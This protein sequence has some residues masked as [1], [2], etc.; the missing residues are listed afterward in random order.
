MTVSTTSNKIKYDGNGATTLFSFPFKIFKNEELKVIL[1]TKADKIE[2]VLVLDV[3]YTV[4]ISKISNGGEI[5]TTVAHSSD[6]EILIKRVLDQTQE[7]SF[8]ISSNIPEVSIENSLDK[9][10][11]LTQDLKEEIS[12]TIK[13]KEGS[14]HENITIPDPEAGKA[15]LWN[16]AE[17]NLENSTDNFNEI[18]SDSQAA[19]AAAEAAQAISEAARDQAQGYAADASASAAASSWNDVIQ[20]Q[21]SDSPYSVLSTHGGVLFEIDCSGGN[22]VI[23]LP[24]VASL[25]LTKS[26]SC[27]F[28][29]IDNST[30]NITINTNG[31]DELDGNSDKII[32]RQYSGV[33]LIPDAEPI[34][35]T[36]TS[37]TFGETTIRGAGNPSIYKIFDAE[38]NSVVGFTNI[39]INNIDPISVDNDYKV[40]SFPASFPTIILEK[41][42]KDKINSTRFHYSLASG[43]FKVLV[44]DQSSNLL[45]ELEISKSGTAIPIIID[46]PLYNSETTIQLS[47]EDISS[48][49]GLFIDDVVFDDDPH[50]YKNLINTQTSHYTGTGTKGTNNAFRFSTLG[51]K[52]GSHIY[53]YSDSSSL[54]TRFTALR[55][56]TISLSAFVGGPSTSRGFYIR[57]N[58]IDLIRETSNQSPLTDSG[59]GSVIL[60]LDPSDYLDVYSSESGFNNGKVTVS[61]IATNEYMTSAAK[62]LKNYNTDNGDFTISGTGWTTNYASLTPYK[63]SDGKWRISGNMDI[64]LTSGTFGSISISG[65]T[66]KSGYNQS[67]TGLDA[68]GVVRSLRVNGGAGSFDR[69]G[70]FAV[71][72]NW[73]NFDLELEGKPDWAEDVTSNFLAAI[74]KNYSQTVI[75]STDDTE[76]ELNLSNLSIGKMYKLVVNLSG[77]VT[78]G[79]L[80]LLASHNGSTILS[81]IVSNSSITLEEKSTMKAIEFEATAE[82]VVFTKTTT[83]TTKLLSTDTHLTITELNNTESIGSFA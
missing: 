14:D 52:S 58:G 60:D 55:K 62:T 7:T 74:P 56:C 24:S 80:K 73:F 29:K 5:N 79:S 27:G 26:W 25:D 72:D 68:T 41:R 43:T 36:W 69:L 18:V 23:N 46:Y 12:R 54:G 19:Q 57:K 53:E 76:S 48:A 70:T 66:F 22:V 38:D 77:E 15:L 71:S 51:F 49:T 64:S 20:L 42:N 40:D 6:Y 75:L 59:S 82:T 44:K 17:N 34:P 32:T 16:D 50:I 45:R 1:I 9:S 10:V 30:N 47:I 13:L 61:A 31:T 33:T 65:V 39:S 3:D 37:I 35:D 63:T 21:F 8:P 11:M 67:I 4:S 83:G 28:K 78:S 81:P 2:Q